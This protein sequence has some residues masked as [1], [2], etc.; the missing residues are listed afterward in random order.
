MRRYAVQNESQ[1]QP[2]HGT[3]KTHAVYKSDDALPCSLQDIEA[4]ERATNFIHVIGDGTSMDTEVEVSACTFIAVHHYATFCQ[5]LR[6]HL[7]KPPCASVSCI[8]CFT[9]VEKSEAPR[10]NVS[11]CQWGP[12]RIC[13]VCSGTQTKVWTMTQSTLQ[14]LVCHKAE[15]CRADGGVIRWLL[16]NVSAI[17]LC[18]FTI[19]KFLQLLVLDVQDLHQF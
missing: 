4:E 7:T 6:S 15:L 19:R 8:T 18:A 9:A 1:Q 16:T 3:F 11:S 17:L 12:E 10:F 13:M 5:L 2:L 14:F